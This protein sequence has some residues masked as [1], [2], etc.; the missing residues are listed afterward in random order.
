MASLTTI[1]QAD[2]VASPSSRWF[3]LRPSRHQPCWR[4]SAEGRWALG[5]LG[6]L[7][8]V[9]VQVAQGYFVPFDHAVAGWV[10][11]LRSP[12][13]DQVMRAITFFGSSGCVG[14][15][16]VWL[17][18]WAQR[19]RAWPSALRVLGAF[20]LGLF[21]AVVLRLA[22]SQWRPDTLIVPAAMEWRTRFGLA[23]FPSGHAY[24]SAFLFGWL[25]REVDSARWAKL[26][27]WGSLAMIV[28]VGFSRLYLNRHWA[29]DVIGGWLVACVALSLAR[30]TA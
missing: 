15:A 24:R 16:L 8:I 29:T 27:R 1:N 13:W 19:R 20:G 3:F 4:G 11:A 2:N 30:R 25:M 6:V 22:V 23:G 18:L 7:T 5:L 17:G 28:L 14:L 9:A 10:A 12:V 26:I 21:V